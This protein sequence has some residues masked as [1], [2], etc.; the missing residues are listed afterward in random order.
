MLI[1]DKS[2]E[3][4]KERHSFMVSFLKEFFKETN[5]LNWINYLDKFIEKE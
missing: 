2:K 3:I 1:L 5:N 4:A